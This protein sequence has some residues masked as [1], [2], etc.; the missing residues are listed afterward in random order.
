MEGVVT[1]KYM[2]EDIVLSTISV[3]IVLVVV[4][5]T[6]TLSVVYVVI[7]DMVRNVSIVD[8]VVGIGNTAVV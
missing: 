3:V 8:T 5:G 2:T 6:V 4:L 1:V 7:D